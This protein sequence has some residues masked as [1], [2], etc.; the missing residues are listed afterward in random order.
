MLSR[1]Q[2]K[3]DRITD[4]VA[5]LFLLRIVN[6]EWPPKDTFLRHSL[7]AGMLPQVGVSL[8]DWVKTETGCYL[9]P[10]PLGE[11]Y[12][13][14]VKFDPD[15]VRLAWLETWCDKLRQAWAERR[16]RLRRDK[17]RSMIHAYV[18]LKVVRD[19]HTVRVGEFKVNG[20]F[21]DAEGKRI[22]QVRA[23]RFDK[24]V[25]TKFS[26]PPGDLAI[27][28]HDAFLQ[29]LH[30]GAEIAKR[31]KLCRNRQCQYPFFLAG[32]RTEKYCTQECAKPAKRAAKLKWWNKHSKKW[33]RDQKAAGRRKKQSQ[34]KGGKRK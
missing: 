13:R 21:L 24:S 20:G 34:Q 15:T 17:L 25:E 31:M 1:T 11:P 32:R 22:E 29:V 16:T 26:E 23:L 18:A 27:T 8:S 2:R 7:F 33:R 9:L 3:S 10:S 28:A 19:Q 14:E 30:R 4:T 6:L 5:D 12:S